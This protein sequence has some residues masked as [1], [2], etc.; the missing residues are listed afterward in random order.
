M[1]LF[2]LYRH[3][4]AYSRTSTSNLHAISSI[5]IYMYVPI[6]NSI[7]YCSI[8]IV[9]CIVPS[10]KI[11]NHCSIFFVFFFSICLGDTI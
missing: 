9:C 8:R 3:D 4:I 1:V 11:D 7:S 5:C 10:E 2:E 6:F